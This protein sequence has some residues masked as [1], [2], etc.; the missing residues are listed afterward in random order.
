MNNLLLTYLRKFPIEYGK[1]WLADKVNLPH[2]IVEYTSTHN[3]TWSLDLDEYQM[4]QIY[5]YD[6]YEKNTIRHLLKLCKPNFTF[7]DVG[8]NIGFYSITM[9]KFLSQGQ[10]HSFEPNPYIFKLFQNNLALNNLPNIKA[11]PFGLSDKSETLTIRFS[12]SN[13]G[14]SSVYKTNSDFSETIQLRP[15]DEYCNE[16]NIQNIDVI[17]VDIEGGELSFLKGATKTIN[18]MPKLILVMEIIEEHCKKAGYSPN[19]LLDYVTKTLGF[20][21][22]LPKPYPFPLKKVDTILSGYND[23]IIFLKGY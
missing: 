6:I 16:N 21:A 4:R 15:F 5:L 7:I 9:A 2:K 13:L 17:K 20:T 23:N 8:T 1:H 10:V 22:Y 14:T 18:R 12:K 11:N 19:E 3:I